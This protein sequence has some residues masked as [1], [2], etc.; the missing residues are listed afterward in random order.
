MQVKKAAWLFLA[1]I[2]VFH[3]Q[4]SHGFIWFLIGLIISLII[5]AVQQAIKPPPPPP[6]PPP[7]EPLPPPEEEKPKEESSGKD[8]K[9]KYSS[10][11]KSKTS[12]RGRRARRSFRQRRRRYRRRKCYKNRKPKLRIR[13]WQVPPNN[14]YY[15]QS[16]LPNQGYQ[17]LPNAYNNNAYSYTNN[18]QMVAPNYY[19]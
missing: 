17:Q 6:P 18:N 16:Y 14:P 15:S 8:K 2:L 13:Y 11:G 1:I 10:G 19:M 12:R 3:A 9:D 5:T 7:P 4:P